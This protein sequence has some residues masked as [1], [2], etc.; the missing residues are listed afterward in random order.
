MTSE[1]RRRVLG[2]TMAARLL[3]V[4]VAAIVV[5]WVVLLSVGA[6]TS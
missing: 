4:V 1:V 6:A 2:L 3:W 5:V